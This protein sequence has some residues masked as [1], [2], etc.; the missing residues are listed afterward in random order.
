[1]TCLCGGKSRNLRNAFYPIQNCL[2]FWVLDLIGAQV[3]P[4][5]TSCPRG[6]CKQKW[7]GR[8]MPD[9]QKCVRKLGAPCQCG[10]PRFCPH[11]VPC[12]GYVSGMSNFRLNLVPC[13]VFDPTLVFKFQLLSSSEPVSV[14]ISHFLSSFCPPF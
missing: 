1:M 8:N 3:T 9:S 12:P 11:S 10:S 5:L 14:L 4:L 2:D 13:P 6:K 7:W